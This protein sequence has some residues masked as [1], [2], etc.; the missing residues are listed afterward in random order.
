MHALTSSL[1]SKAATWTLTKGKGRN[2]K[3][4]KTDGRGLPA[5]SN[6]SNQN[7]RTNKKLRTIS[8]VSRKS[9]TPC[10]PWLAHTAK[11]WNTTSKWQN[12]L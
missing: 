4:K 6:P 1:G 11:S 12:V 9:S 5:T 3:D 10:L 2:T 8:I 7:Y